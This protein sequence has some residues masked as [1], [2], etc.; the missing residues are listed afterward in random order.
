MYVKLKSNNYKSQYASGSIAKNTWEHIVVFDARLH[1]KR[2]THRI[3][4]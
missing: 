1:M 3:T 4:L 2:R